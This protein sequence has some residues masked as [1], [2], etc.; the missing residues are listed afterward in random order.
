MHS[1]SLL[2]SLRKLCRAEEG[3]TAMEFA[4]VA[5]PLLLLLMG[6]IEL[7][8]IF[9]AQNAIESAI[10]N[11]SRLGKTGY[12]AQGQSRQSLIY[13]MI[14]SR[15]GTLINTA[16]LTITSLSYGQISQ[17]GQPEAYVDSN[18]NQVH[19]SSESYTDT[20]GNG[21]WDS[22]MG[23]EGLGGAGDI[24]VYT[25]SYPWSIQ[26]PILSQVFGTAGYYTIRSNV[27][28]RNE[29]YDS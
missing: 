10:T 24:V 17:I 7:S 22:D 25:V 1:S 29:P 16:N 5:P 6:T 15:A 13:G 14:Q 20:N 2:K 8:V 11:S 9:T 26:T 18:G 21:Q 27:V 23:A 12:T 4:F 19:D 28:V 3:V